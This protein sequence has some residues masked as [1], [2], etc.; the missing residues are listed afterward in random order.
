MLASKPCY[1]HEGLLEQSMRRKRRLEYREY[2]RRSLDG[3]L[4]CLSIRVRFLLPEKIMM[5]VIL[6]SNGFPSG[7]TAVEGY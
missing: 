5:P 4:Q 2:Q 6:P 3:G 7:M 1:M